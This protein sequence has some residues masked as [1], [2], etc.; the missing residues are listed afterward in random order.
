M[1]LLGEYFLQCTPSVSLQAFHTCS[2]AAVLL[3]H[4]LAVQIHHQVQ[5]E[6]QMFPIGLDHY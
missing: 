3:L 5:L 4:L 6:C 1:I 2:E